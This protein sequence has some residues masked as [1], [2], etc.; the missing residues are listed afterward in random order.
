MSPF[1]NTDSLRGAAVAFCLI[2]GSQYIL[3]I[4]G[5]ILHLQRIPYGI[6]FWGAVA[7]FGLVA[8]SFAAIVFARRRYSFALICGVFLSAFS[9]VQA[10]STLTSGPSV[11]EDWMFVSSTVVNC[12]LTISFLWTLLGLHRGLKR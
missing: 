8:A 6:A 1:K 11:G 5:V 2:V 7:R 10:Y 12:L 9:I 3:P 4:L